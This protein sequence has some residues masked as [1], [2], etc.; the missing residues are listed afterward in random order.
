MTFSDVDVGDTHTAS[1]SPQGGGYVGT[2]SLDPVSES[3][4]SG[5]V[6]WHFSVD[7]ADI[8]FLASGQTVT[9]SYT[10]EITDSDGATGVQTVDIALTG[11][12]DAP[13]AVNDSLISNAGA[14]GSTFA[15]S[16]ALVH[17]DTD[18][19]TIDTLSVNSVGGASGG[20]A[21]LFGEPIFTDDATL[22]GSFTYDAVDNHGAVSNSATVTV[23]NLASTTTTLVG[24][25]GNDIIV[26]LNDGDTLQGGGGNDI[27]IGI[28]NTNTMTGGS[29]N[30][31]FAVEVM[32]SSP[33]T[34]TDFNNTSDHDTIA[35]N[36]AAFGGGLAPHQ[37]LTFDFE[38]VERRS[39]LRRDPVPLR[40]GEP[41]ALLQRRLHPGL[42]GC[43]VDGTAECDAARERPLRGLTAS[44][45]QR[46]RA[47]DRAIGPGR[48]F[49]YQPRAGSMASYFITL[50]SHSAMPG[51][52]IRIRIASM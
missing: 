30:D 15:P 52:H 47:P 17:N 13:T 39:V 26:G 43:G 24:T 23:T 2:F 37:D 40:R 7:N 25:G 12:N 36:S 41:H 6:A 50:G 11:T 1:F 22:G 5:S 4:G 20:S 32:P 21:I 35:I 48:C 19:D 18:P 33:L 10:V 3:G 46:Q 38:F 45:F 28:G 8:Q 31:I 14:N 44:G 42:R 29:G 34:I 49:L 9:Q 51:N 27:L 16:W